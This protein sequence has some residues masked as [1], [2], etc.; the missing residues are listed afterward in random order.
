MDGQEEG[1]GSR[2]E[3]CVDARVRARFSV[4]SI[5]CTVTVYSSGVWGGMQSSYYGT[6]ITKQHKDKQQQ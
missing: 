1:M 5:Q 4:Y 6:T 2:Q 3:V